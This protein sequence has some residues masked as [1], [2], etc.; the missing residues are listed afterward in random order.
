MAVNTEE[1]Q[2]V[3]QQV[4][5]ILSAYGSVSAVRGELATRGFVVKA[6]HGDVVSMENA[7]AEIFVLI[8]AGEAGQ[9][10]G[11]HVTTFDEIELKPQGKS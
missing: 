8:R 3:L 6:E 5:D 1:Q 11:S 10:A 2:K 9:V 7:D 4:H